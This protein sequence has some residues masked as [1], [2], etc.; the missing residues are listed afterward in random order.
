MQECG[1]KMT[2]CVGAWEGSTLNGIE[3]AQHCGGSQALQER[4]GVRQS[5][6]GRPFV[7]GHKRGLLRRSWVSSR[8]PMESV[9]EAMR[10]Y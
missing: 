5:S 7:R 8:T 3:Q 4:V 6:M 9:M 10:L 2:G 1:V